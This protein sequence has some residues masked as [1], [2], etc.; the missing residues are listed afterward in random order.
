MTAKEANAI[1]DNVRK[2][3]VTA[4][5]TN[6]YHKIES[7]ARN[8]KNNI[9]VY[10]AITPETKATLESDGYNVKSEDHRNERTVTISW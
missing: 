9:S 5:A 1:A 3:R 6:I 7:A 4:E 2:T 10:S 8:G